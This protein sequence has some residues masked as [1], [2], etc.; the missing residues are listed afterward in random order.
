MKRKTA[1]NTL[2]GAVVGALPILVGFLAVK[3]IT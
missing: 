2:F 1:F 3:P